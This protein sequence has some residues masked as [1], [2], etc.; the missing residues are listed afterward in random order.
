MLQGGS[1]DDTFIVADVG[2]NIDGG[3]GIDT[4]SYALS[5]SGV[6]IDL[7]ASVGAPTSGTFTGG[8]LGEGLD[9]EGSFLYA[10]NLGGDGAGSI[11]VRD[12]NFEET[13]FS[14]TPAGVSIISDLQITNFLTPDLGSSTDDNNIETVMQSI[15]WV[16][17]DGIGIEQFELQLDNISVGEMY[18][19]QLMFA[20]PNIDGSR[21]FNID[22]EGVTVFPDVAIAQGTVTPDFGYVYTYSFYC[23]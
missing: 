2:N 12:A 19:L 11:A 9:L 23:Y 10:L 4:V 7:T 15:R 13:S 18:K 21:G 1:G 6:V 16:N 8:D 3:T 14:I 5:A 20:D 17:I 22:I